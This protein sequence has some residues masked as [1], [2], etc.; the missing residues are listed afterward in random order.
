MNTATL[1]LWL[2][3]VDAVIHIAANLDGERYAKVIYWTKPFL[4]PLLIAYLVTSGKDAPGLLIPALTFGF[5]G[6]MFLMIPGEKKKIFMAGLV[7]FLINQILYTVIFYRSMGGLGDLPLWIYPLIV[8]YVAYGILMYRLLEKG[9]DGLKIPVIVYMIAILTMGV[10]ALLRVT[11]FGGE[12]TFW[13]VL[14]GS[15][16]F[17][18]SDSVLA[19]D[20]FRKRLPLNRILIMSTYI[21]AQFLI[22]QGLIS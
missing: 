7:T 9:L 20:K 13:L 5:L 1:I 15:L 6:D 14:M 11:A 19:F 2:F 21:A 8:L 16:I 18:V 22:V 4:M 17:I 3:I 10:A 12:C